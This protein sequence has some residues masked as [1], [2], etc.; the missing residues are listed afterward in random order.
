MFHASQCQVDAGLNIICPPRHRKLEIEV[1]TSLQVAFW[2]IF[3]PNK[4]ILQVPLGYTS[5]SMKPYAVFDARRLS[6]R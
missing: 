5:K 2:K 6:N 4:L 1:N 3:M